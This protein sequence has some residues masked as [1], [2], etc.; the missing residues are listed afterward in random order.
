MK[1]KPNIY[2]NISC[3]LRYFYSGD[4]FDPVPMLN[5]AVA[6][7]ICQIV[8][9]R[10]FDYTDHLFQSMLKNLTEMAYLE[11][12][13]WALVR[14]LDTINNLAC[15]ISTVFTKC[16]RTMMLKE[17]HWK[18]WLKKCRLVLQF[19]VLYLKT[20]WA[21][22]WSSRGL[23]NSVFHPNSY[24]IHSHHWWNTCPGLT[25]A[26]SATANL[27]WHLLGER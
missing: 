20:F 4:P 24:M 10:R 2:T 17:A 18:V 19:K 12:S 22:V 16:C 1:S 7:I 8:F 14:C 13:I 3:D 11:G 26:S 6:N 21:K 25:T 5:N 15:L 9:G 27:W 23:I